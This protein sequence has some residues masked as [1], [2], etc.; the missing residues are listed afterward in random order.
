MSIRARV[1]DACVAYAVGRPEAALTLV[2]AAVGATSRRRRPA[3][4]PSV[5]HAGS[6]MGDGE[7]F[8]AFLWEEMP[9][10][11]KVQ[12]Y[13]VAYRGK[14]HRM[15]RVLYK[16][17]RCELFHAAAL[18]ADLRFE[19]DPRPGV[20]RVAVEKASGGLLLTHGWIDGLVDAVVHAPENADQFGTPPQPPLPIHLP[21]ID[22][23][24]SH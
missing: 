19:P 4:T 2:L 22:M 23:T 16:W 17:F 13:N 15:E 18:P 12:N 3:G 9:R 20:T 24:V 5:R 11:C 8:E 1:E 7:A 21:K 10:I 14:M 6:E